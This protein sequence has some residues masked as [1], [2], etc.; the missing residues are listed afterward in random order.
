MRRLAPVGL[1]VAAG[2][3]GGLFG[4]GGG[5]VMVPGMVLFMGLAQHRAH[6]T[7]VAAIVAASAAAVTPLAVE[8]EVH[9]E[10]AGLLLAGAV[11]GAYLG[12]RF[13]DRLSPLW[14]AR[15][16]VLLVIVAALRMAFTGEASGDGT[17]ADAVTLA[18]AV[19]WV[20]IGL[21]AG[22]LAAML[23]IGGG[24]VFVPA[25]ATLF[26]FPQHEAQATSL[27]VLA[28]TTLVA[29]VVHARAGRVEWRL[30]VPLGLGGILGGVLGASTALALEAPLLRRLFAG[31]L[32]AMA[33]RMLAKT[34]AGAGSR[35]AGSS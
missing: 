26:S 19:G 31:F 27:A 23:G 35:A 28:P 15:A 25:L 5:L 34:R 16:F 7:S 30:A 10:T 13:I 17:A 12:A 4:V 33:F 24:I 8:G 14:L 3:F 2:F 11:V 29:A 6:A 1:G 18:G 21:A 9:W 20:G 32:V 22:T